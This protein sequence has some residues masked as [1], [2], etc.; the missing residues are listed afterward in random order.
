[1]KLSAWAWKVIKFILE[2]FGK[3]FFVLSLKKLDERNKHFLRNMEIFM[4]EE[5]FWLQNINTDKINKIKIKIEIM[6]KASFSHA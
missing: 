2:N 6:Q 1:M 5:G 4:S 3:F